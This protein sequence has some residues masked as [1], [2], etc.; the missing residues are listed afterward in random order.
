MIMESQKYMAMRKE[1]L[2]EIRRVCG[3]LRS[4]PTTATH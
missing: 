3:D 2:L 4:A 1:K